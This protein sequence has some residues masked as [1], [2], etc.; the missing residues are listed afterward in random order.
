M[1]YLLESVNKLIDAV[2]MLCDAIVDAFMGIAELAMDSLEALINTELD[3]GFLNTVWKWVATAAGY[4]NDSKLTMAA[5]ISLMAA[6]PCTVI[7]K[8]I[9]GVANEPFPTGQF[10]M[11]RKLEIV[12]GTSAFGIDMP[13]GCQLAS[14]ILQII[15]VVPAGLGD[16]LGNDAPWWVTAITIGFS[17]AIWALAHGYPDLSTLEWTITGVVVANLL[18][19]APAVYFVVQSVATAFL[20]KVKE[21]FGDIADVIITV[22]GVLR[23]IVAA[24]LDFVTT[25]NPGQAIANILIPLPSIFGFC[26]MSTFRDDPDVAPFAIAVNLVFDFIGYVGGGVIEMIEVVASKRQPE[27]PCPAS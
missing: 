11:G 17:I 4:P 19:I 24:V 14:T 2:L 22:Y 23:F 27:L 7:Y 1:P 15:Y 18:W 26:N 13:W 9:D 10:P 12:P 5:L 8:L 16:Y 20:Q 25:V 3:L 6:F 21:N